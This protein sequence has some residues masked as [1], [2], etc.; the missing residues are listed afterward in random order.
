MVQK[1]RL[2]INPI[3]IKELRSR[4]RGARAFIILTTTLLILAGALY[5][6]YRLSL[7][8]AGFT[9]VPGPVIGQSLF[10]SLAVLELLII[11]FITPALTAG[12]ISSEREK[13]TYEML[14][15]TPL[16]PARILWGKLVSAL[17][18]VLLLIFAAIP[19]ASLV[20]IF[21][22][23]TP[24]SMLRGLVV[25][26]ALAI[27]LGTT[28]IFMSAWL[29]R[30]A[31]ATVL[32]YLFVLLIFIGP[33]IAYISVGIYEQAEPP[34]E[35]LI[36]NPLSAL[37]SAILPAGT[38]FIMQFGGLGYAL[39]GNLSVMNGE[40]TGPL[41]PLFHYSLPLYAALTL[42]FYF[43][44]AQLVRPT[45]RWRIDW[46]KALITIIMVGLVSG[47]VAFGFWRTQEQ[48]ES[49]PRPTPTVN[50]LFPIPV[51]RVVE[52][53]AEPKE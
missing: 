26:V 33:L 14:L 29:G 13:L 32:S 24:W 31:R 34:R 2:N 45:Q 39:S 5:G 11:C 10:Q 44:A 12:S 49:Q 37:F 52:E 9:T 16:S 43:L 47:L 38:S 17:S 53:E 41:R 8:A 18:Y 20:F 42:I 27:L 22:G 46:R 7:L 21:G 25:L 3:M 6:I 28:G 4:M 1:E 30:T 35:L 48:Y 15:T 51:P 50:A 19:I 40:V 23:V 36:A